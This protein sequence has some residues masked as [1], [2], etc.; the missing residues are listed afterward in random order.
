[1]IPKLGAFEGTWR[2]SRE[3]WPAGAPQAQFVGEARF[4][5]G[6]GG[7]VYSEEG[8]LTLDGQQ[9][10]R[11]ERTYLWRQNDEQ[12][13]AVF[14]ADGRAFHTFGTEQLADR[15]WCDP[16][17]YDVRYDFSDW[18]RWSTSWRVSGPRK[19]YRMISRYS[20]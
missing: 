6:Q 17:T 18:P 9:P 13:V 2:L 5:P 15:H 16:D 14:F 12:S 11:A 10:V 1:M 4:A 7:L 8:L 3:I 19:D 20:A